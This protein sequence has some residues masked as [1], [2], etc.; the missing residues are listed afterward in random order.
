[1]KTFFDS[2]YRGFWNEIRRQSLFLLVKGPVTRR[3]V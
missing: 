3:A 2:G 1:V